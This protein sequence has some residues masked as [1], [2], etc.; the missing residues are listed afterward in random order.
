MQ[1][2]VHH[3]LVDEARNPVAV[4]LAYT[5][6]LEIQRR[7]NIEPPPR[8]GEAVGNDRAHV[9]DVLQRSSGIWKQGDGLEYQRRIRVEWDRS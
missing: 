1:S 8:S 3:I 9:Q 4:Q 6:W 2:P 5:D 7:L